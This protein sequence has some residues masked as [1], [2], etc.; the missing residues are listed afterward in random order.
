M[1]WERTDPEVTYLPPHPSPTR[2][3]VPQNIRAEANRP[4]SSG[5]GNG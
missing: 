4:I 3:N 5:G 1:Q 2:P